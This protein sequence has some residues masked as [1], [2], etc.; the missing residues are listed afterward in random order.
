M[1]KSV[2]RSIIAHICKL[3]AKTFTDLCSEICWVLK[4]TRNVQL[5]SLDIDFEERRRSIYVRSVHI[6]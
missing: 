4:V 5:R 6:K 1:L 2:N 3:L